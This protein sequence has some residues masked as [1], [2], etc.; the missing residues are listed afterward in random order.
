MITPP[1]PPTDLM[2]LFIA[3][4]TAALEL[5]EWVVRRYNLG[6]THLDAAMVTVL[7]QL[8]QAARFDVYFGYDVSAAPAALRTPIQAYM[9]ALRGGGAKRARA[10]LPQS[11]IRAHRRVIRVVEGPQRR[12]NHD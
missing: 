10:E 7:P 5:R 9:T 8:D 4:R 1:P 11:L 3:A 12:R 6:D 2:I